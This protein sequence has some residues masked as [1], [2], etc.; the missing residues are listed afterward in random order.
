MENMKIKSTY[1][2]SIILAIFVIGFIIGVFIAISTPTP[3]K[4]IL[5][6]YKFVKD[7]NYYILGE[8]TSPNGFGDVDLYIVDEEEYDDFLEG[9]EYSISTT[10]MN[11]WNKMYK[12]V[13]KYKPM[14]YD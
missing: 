14:I 8:T 11:H 4:F 3:Y 9:F 7:G 6:Q 10:G 12:K 2:I 1:K 13:S 5:V